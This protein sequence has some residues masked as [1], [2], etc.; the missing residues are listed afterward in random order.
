MMGGE[1]FLTAR[2]PVALAASVLALTAAGCGCSETGME[3]RTDAAA[4]GALDPTSEDP[5]DTM[6]DSPGST[7]NIIEQS[8]CPAG[9][10][11]SWEYD[12]HTCSLVERCFS[13]PPGTLEIW[14][15]CE[16]SGPLC[17][18]GTEC[19]ETREFDGTYLWRCHE[20]CRSDG[21]C[22]WRDTVCLGTP[23]GFWG[24][25]PCE[26]EPIEFPYGICSYPE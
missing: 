14:E 1:T 24:Y 21:D 25:G 18:P 10:W 5:F 8:G 20:W 26:G 4:D 17:Q 12:E 9:T 3:G 19:W 23:I 6:S 11:C 22:S 13:R 7:C 16:G 2:L 15:P